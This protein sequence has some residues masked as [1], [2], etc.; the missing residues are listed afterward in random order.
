VQ[1]YITN[2]LSKT[3]EMLQ[4]Q[5]DELMRKLENE[6]H[7]SLRYWSCMNFVE[8]VRLDAERYLEQRAWRVLILHACT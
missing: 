1:E 3:V 4:Q 8:L 2:K 7:V 5:K 6:Q